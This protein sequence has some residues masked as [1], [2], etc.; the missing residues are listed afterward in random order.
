MIL[1]SDACTTNTVRPYNFLF[2]SVLCTC[3]L[4]NVNFARYILLS[5]ENTFLFQVANSFC[6]YLNIFVIHD[7]TMHPILLIAVFKIEVFKKVNEN[8]ILL[9]NI[10]CLI[11]NIFQP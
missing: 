11:E 2:L 6:C 4:R 7:A 1:V 9:V 10:I 8:L 3:V 5:S